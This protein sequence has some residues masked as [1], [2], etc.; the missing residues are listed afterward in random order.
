MGN[1]FTKYMYQNI[2]SASLRK[3]SYFPPSNMQFIVLM[4]YA[5]PLPIAKLF[6]QLLNYLV[7]PFSNML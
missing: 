1:G 2:F 3:Y 4:N 5:F 7:K 6:M